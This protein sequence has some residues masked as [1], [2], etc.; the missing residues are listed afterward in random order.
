MAEWDGGVRI[1]QQCEVG[2]WLEVVGVGQ[3]EEGTKGEWGRIGYGT[4]GQGR[5]AEAVFSRLVVR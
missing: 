4:A 2:W 3:E 1:Q 5:R